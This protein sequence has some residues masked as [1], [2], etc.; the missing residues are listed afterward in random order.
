[1]EMRKIFLVEDDGAIAE[2]V[3][4]HLESWGY[5]CAVCRDLRRVMEEFTAE[6]PQLVILDIGLPYRNGYHWCAEIRRVSRVPILFLSSASDSMDLVMAVNQG[7]DDFLAKPFDLSVLTAK[8]QALLRRSYDFAPQGET[9]I[10]GELGLEL[11]P[12]EGS[13]SRDGAAVSLTRNE[14]RILQVLWEHRGKVVSRETLMQRLWATDAFVDT[15][16]LTVNVNRLRGKLEQL[17]LRELIVTK[18]GEGYLL[19]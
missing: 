7:G 6:D 12:E 9:R 13:L 2:G 4:R 1:M 17:G 18:K 8:V 15:N 19:P 14:Q 5:P 11:R 16:T 10:L 3:R